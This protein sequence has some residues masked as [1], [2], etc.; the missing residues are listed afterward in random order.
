MA[1]GRNGINS[2]FSSG[3]FE[4]IRSNLIINCIR[5]EKVVHPHS[6]SV[7]QMHAVKDCSNFHFKA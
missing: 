6:T 5:V 7:V 2:A 1:N 4:V 3:S